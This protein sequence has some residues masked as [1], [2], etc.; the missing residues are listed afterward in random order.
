MQGR[1]LVRQRQNV[2]VC[3]SWTGWVCYCGGHW[4]VTNHHALHFVCQCTIYLFMK[5]RFHASWFWRW[6][7]RYKKWRMVLKEWVP[8]VAQ[9]QALKTR[10]GGPPW[11]YTLL[12]FTN[13]SIHISSCSFKAV[14]PLDWDTFLSD[15]KRMQRNSQEQVTGS[16]SYFITTTSPFPLWRYQTFPTLMKMLIEFKWD[17]IHIIIIIYEVK[18]II[19]DHTM[20]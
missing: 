15:S 2:K 17:I 9:G 6:K 1:F 7:D 12:S 4:T 18:Y 16:Q 5:S 20:A 19:K 11:P 10:Q 14:G 8:S 3:D 13:H